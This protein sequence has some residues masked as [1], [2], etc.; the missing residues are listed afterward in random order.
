M[1]NERRDIAVSHD[2]CPDATA[3]A[4]EG[5]APRLGLAARRQVVIWRDCVASEKLL[6]GGHL[7]IRHGGYCYQLRQTAAGKLILT[8]E[9][10]FEAHVVGV[11]QD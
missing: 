1:K 11:L 10:G 9:P 5:A 4:V 8:K 7:L 3:E 6:C 2:R